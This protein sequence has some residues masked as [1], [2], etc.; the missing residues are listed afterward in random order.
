M[1]LGWLQLYQ[2][3]RL[4]AGF[5]IM[6]AHYCHGPSVNM[7]HRHGFPQKEFCVWIHWHRPFGFSPVALPSS[8]RSNHNH[9]KHTHTHTHTHT[10]P[11][12]RARVEENNKLEWPSLKPCIAEKTLAEGNNKQTW[13]ALSPTSQKRCQTLHA[14]QDPWQWW[15]TP[16]LVI[17]LLPFWEGRVLETA[18]KFAFMANSL[19]ITAPSRQRRGHSR[20]LAHIQN[21]TTNRQ[22]SFFLATIQDWNDWP[23]RW[24]HSNSEHSRHF[25][26]HHL[27]IVYPLT[28]GVIWGITAYFTT[29]FLHFSLSSTALWDLANA[30]PVHSLKLS[31][32]RPPSLWF[33]RWFWPNLMNGRHVHTTAVC[34]SNYGGQEVSVWSDCLVDLGTDILVGTWCLYEMCSI[35]RKHLISMAL[36]LLCS[37]AARVHDS[38][39]YGKMDV[40]RE[41]ISRI[42][43]LREVLLPYQ[44]GFNLVNAAVVC[45][46]LESISGK[47]ISSDTTQ[48]GYLK[49]VTLS[50][51]CPFTLTGLK[52]PTNLLTN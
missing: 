17:R 39:A 28:T 16:S 33:A 41:H 30:R 11:C 37:S 46:I 6:R 23:A 2:L 36:I 5:A 38:Y 24:Q 8:M 49:Y 48:P 35:L 40:T 42:I 21:R 10:P 43:E 15:R 45:A 34:V 3:I 18:L 12:A 27:I 13:V 25:Q 47:E 4:T 44:T 52:A 29:S 32:H 20:Q 9:L 50:S 7:R 22:A 19:S 14:L 26:T 31:P 51:F 1:H